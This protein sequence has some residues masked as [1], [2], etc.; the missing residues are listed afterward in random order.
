MNLKTVLML[1]ILGVIIGAS[2]PLFYPEIYSPTAFTVQANNGTVNSENSK[3]FL[4][5]EDNCAQQLVL[6]YATASK[7]IHIMIYSLTK[8]EIAQALIQAKN[9]GIEVKVLI[10]KGQAGLKDAKDEFLIENG[11][12]LKRVEI[13]GYSIFHN[14]VSIIDGNAFSTGSFNYTQNA[15]SGSAENLLIVKDKSM[16]ER[17]EQEFQ[18]YWQS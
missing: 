16:A 4:C 7:S 15:D 8:E 13:P 10:D 1:L 3:L 5:P 6:F 9:N 17:F 18:K 12:E 2:L 14:K 11:V